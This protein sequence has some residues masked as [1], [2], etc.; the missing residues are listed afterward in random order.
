MDGI[1]IFF[2]IAGISIWIIVFFICKSSAK[3]EIQREGNEIVS[4]K[5]APFGYGWFGEKDAFIFKIKYIDKD[6]RIHTV[7]CKSGIFSGVYF[8][9]EDIDK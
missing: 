2:I 8:S 7:Y 6:N 3:Y 5:W 4:I 9:K 1:L